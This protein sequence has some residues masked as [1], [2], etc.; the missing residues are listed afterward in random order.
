MESRDRT[1]LI[2]DVRYL[3][4][5]E[6]LTSRHPDADI[7]RRINA[8]IRALRSFVTS[9][10]APYF[11]TSTSPATLESTQVSGEAYSEVPWPTDAVSIL[12]VDV[13]SASG[14]ADWRPL[15]PIGWV[16]RRNAVYSGGPP[17]YFAVRTLPEGNETSIDAGTIDI[18]PAASSGRYKIWYL[19]D[20][21]DLDEGD[22]V[23]AGLPEWHDWVVWTVVE[24][25]AAR[26]DDQRE[27]Y[28]IARAKKA[29]AEA[30]ILHSIGRITA[31]GPL[32]PRRRLRRGRW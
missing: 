4:D 9:K 17:R 6:G 3:G 12:G 25:L 26:D 31:A 32:R 10:G 8:A 21:T 15:E 27:T 22:D 13:E 28:Q 5:T 14:L 23:F 29:E 20:F 30:R 16:Q 2:A 11:L 24:D 19:E 7:G 18:F 1:R